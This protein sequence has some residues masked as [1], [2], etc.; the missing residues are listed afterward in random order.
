MRHWI[1]LLIIALVVAGIAYCVAWLLTGRDNGL[2][3]AEPDG[4]AT[5]LPGTR[6]LVEPDLMA[7]RFDTVVRGYRM[8]QV[9][10]A[11]RRAAYD[12]GYK[13]E[14]INV[15]EAEVQALR[16]GRLADAE[17]LRR[18]RDGAQVG[19]P[20][21]AGVEPPAAEDEGESLATVPTDELA[22]DTGEADAAEL[23]AA[24]EAAVEDEPAETEVEPV[25][26]AKSPDGAV[27]DEEPAP[28]GVVA[29][30]EPAPDG[31]V[32][33]EE[34]VPD[35]AVADGAVA[36]GAVA[37]GA[38]ADEPVADEPA[39][40]EPVTEEPVAVEEDEV[41]DQADQAPIRR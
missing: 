41:A 35:G 29:D 33:D 4:R 17:T 39:S 8:D 11:L 6:P 2:E 10:S 31:V 26:E 40:D 21:P 38:V 36:D 18:A 28:D 34:P 32:A 20:T 12:I 7:V 9:D 22:V 37:D 14:L 27:A 5:P 23:A 24:D 15:L 19:L 1:L 13:G 16:D 25:L 3:D 30:E